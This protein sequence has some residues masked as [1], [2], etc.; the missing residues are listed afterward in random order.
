MRGRQWECYAAAFLGMTRGIQ[1]KYSY[2]APYSGFDD[3]AIKKPPHGLHTTATVA[4]ENGM[5]EPRR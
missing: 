4:I 5:C 3:T 2:N 1:A